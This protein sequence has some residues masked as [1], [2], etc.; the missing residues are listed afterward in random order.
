[1]LGFLNNAPQDLVLN[2]LES[3]FFTFHFLTSPTIGDGQSNIDPVGCDT[4]L[5]SGYGHTHDDGISGF[6]LIICCL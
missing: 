4:W 6:G 5:L 3:L 1:M 2:K